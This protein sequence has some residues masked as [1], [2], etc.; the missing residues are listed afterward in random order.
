MTGTELVL[1][2]SDQD[3]GAFY[4]EL[5]RRAAERRAMRSASRRR[6]PGRRGRRGR[7]AWLDR[8]LLTG[9]A[10]ALALATAIA[11]AVLWPSGSIPHLQ[12]AVPHSQGAHV[13]AV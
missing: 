4:D 13:L 11:I 1:A 2:M 7:A 9:L 5:D 8:R 12:S 10:V 6:R 3:L